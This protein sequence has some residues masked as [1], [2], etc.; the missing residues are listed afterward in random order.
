MMLLLMSSS[1]AAAVAVARGRS[2]MEIVTM[3][4]MNNDSIA[5]V[6][7]VNFSG[8]YLLMFFSWVF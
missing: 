1:A 6:V 8:I 2:K 7:G 4:T 3:T 5:K